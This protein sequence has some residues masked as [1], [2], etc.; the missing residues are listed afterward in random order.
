M[1]HLSVRCCQPNSG[2]RL[3]RSIALGS[4]TTIKC[5]AL[6]KTVPGWALYFRKAVRAGDPLVEVPMHLGQPINALSDG[7]SG[8]RLPKMCVS[9]EY[10]FVGARHAAENGVQLVVNVKYVGNALNMHM[11]LLDCVLRK[12]KISYRCTHSC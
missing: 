8:A 6:T 2:A 4:S 1:D 12:R 7:V 11:T 10:P 3:S 5:G 9:A